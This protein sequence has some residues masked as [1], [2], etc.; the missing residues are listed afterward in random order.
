MQQNV[1]A[2]AIASLFSLAHAAV[3]QGMG[4]HVE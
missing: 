4:M 2:H 1:E 3:G